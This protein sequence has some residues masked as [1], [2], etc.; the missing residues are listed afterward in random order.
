MLGAVVV[1]DVSTRFEGR[2]DGDDSHGEGAALSGWHTF[3]H[4]LD[5]T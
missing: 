1:V 4:E 5:A 2:T 3:V